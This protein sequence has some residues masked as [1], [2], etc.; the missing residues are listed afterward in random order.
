MSPRPS[1][2]DTFPFDDML[3][4]VRRLV[5]YAP[6][7]L[8]WGSDWPHPQYFRPMPNDIDLLDQ[9]PD[10]VPDEATRQLIFV[11]NPCEIFGFPRP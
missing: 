1:K 11:D 4:L 9:M 6:S 7:R 10:W 8:L 5:D 2:Q 3:P